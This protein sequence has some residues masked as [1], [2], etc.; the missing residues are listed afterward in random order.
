MMESL[1]DAS[2]AVQVVGYAYVALLAVALVVLILWSVI[3]WLLGRTDKIRNPVGA[4]PGIAVMLGF[5]AAIA[6]TPALFV[7]PFLLGMPLPLA[8]WSLIACMSLYGLYEASQR[9]SGGME[10]CTT[11]FLVGFSGFGLF[12]SGAAILL[13]DPPI[14]NAAS[15]VRPL[16]V[17]APIALFV[18]RH[19]S[20]NRVRQAIGFELI[21][22]LFA[23]IAFL[24]V[25][26]GFAD[27]YL[28]ASDW[29]R[30]PIAGA[31]VFACYPVIAIPLTLLFGSRAIEARK[32]SRTMAMLGLFGLSLGLAWTFPR[33]LF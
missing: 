16:L 26:Q 9:P 7:T 6:A 13:A 15:F 23:A 3:A 31:I 27:L 4:V 20:K 5:P 18:A 12:W 25:E 30:F 28:P 24:P 17:A 33:L 14:G 2:L 29:L 8:G 19:S 11:W 21:I 1:N 32:F 22:A 10:G